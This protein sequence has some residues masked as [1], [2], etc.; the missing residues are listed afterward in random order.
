MQ[1]STWHTYPLPV[2]PSSLAG[3]P[4][5]VLM[6]HLQSCSFPRAAA[7]TR[8]RNGRDAHWG[9][10][11]DRETVSIVLVHLFCSLESSHE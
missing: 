6:G 11:T 1:H 7:P 10:L 8:R 5:V 9:L 3:T 4:E 2:P